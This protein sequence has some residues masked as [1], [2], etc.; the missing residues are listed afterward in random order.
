MDRRDPFPR[1]TPTPAV[2]VPWLVELVRTVPGLVSPAIGPRTRERLIM[3]VTEVNGDRFTAWIHGAWRDFLGGVSEVDAEDAL[4]VYAR[5]CAVAG[6]PADPSPLRQ[7]LPGDAVLAVRATVARAELANLA[8]NS[9]DG[10]AARMAGRR[11]LDPVGAL[12][13]LVTGAAALPVAIPFAGVAAAMRLVARAAPPLPEIEVP[14]DEP[15][16]LVHVLVEGLH[17]WLSNAAV[18]LAVLSLPF[19]VKLALRDGRSAATV[20]I[21]NGRVRVRNGADEDAFLL[22]DGE[23]G[24]LLRAASG[25]FLEQLGHLRIRRA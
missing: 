19:G 25:S 10:L 14:D 11:P 5:E 23:P 18:R 4:L 9:V 17:G 15:N 12:T 16:L 22:I 1:R 2:L 20:T 24:P 7:V 13:E 8:G 3:A 6:R 21:G